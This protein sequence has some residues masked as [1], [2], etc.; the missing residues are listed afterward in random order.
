MDGRITYCREEHDI[1]EF[2]TVINIKTYLIVETILKSKPNIRMIGFFVNKWVEDGED[3]DIIP[4][5]KKYPN[6][7][8]LI[9]NKT[10]I[11][12]YLLRTFNNHKS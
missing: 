7:E 11:S 6:V 1:N 4:M 2:K 9:A 8:F 3:N 5:L 12:P 10:E